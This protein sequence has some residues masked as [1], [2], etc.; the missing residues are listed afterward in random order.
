MDV[1]AHNRLSRLPMWAAVFVLSVCAAIVVLSGWSEW[2]SRDNTLRSAEIELGNLTR[3]LAQHAEDTI[4]LADATIRGAVSA[5][6]TDDGSVTTVLRLR[7]ILRSE[8]SSLGRIRG[9]FAYDENGRWLAT[10]EDVVLSN[11][12]NADRDYFGRHRK[13]ADRSL[14]IG[15]PVQSKSGRQWVI[16]LSRRWNHPD[17]RFAGVVVATIDVDY[18][19]GFY[20]RFDVGPHGTISLMSRDGTMLAHSVDLVADTAPQPLAD[21]IA[22]YPS[23]GILHVQFLQ[24]DSKRIGFYQ[25]G[26]R[27]PFLLLVT[28][29]Q[30]DVL[31]EWKRHSFVRIAV[32]VGLVLLILGIGL[33]LVRLILQGR[34]LASALLSRE[35]NFRLLAEDSSDIVARI[36]PDDRVRYISPSVVRVLGW[37]PAQLL[38]KRA[39]AG[40]HPLDASPI[41]EIILSI[42]R[43]ETEEARATYRIRRR[44]KSEIWVETALSASRNDDGTL[45]GFVAITRDVTQQMMLQGKLETLAVVDGLTGLA[46]R[47]RFDERLLEEWSRAYREKTSLGLLM[48]DIDHFKAFN[49]TYGH[50]A[51][52]ECLHTVAVVLAGEAQRPSDLAARYGGEEFAILLPNT[53]AAGC[54]RIGERIRRAIRET[55]I[56]HRGNAP[57]GIVTASIGGAVCRPGSE[58]PLEHASLIEAADRALY[59][60]KDGGRDRVIMAGELMPLAPSLAPDGDPSLDEATGVRARS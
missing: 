13:S 3:S 28:R 59:A 20:H 10:T 12:N 46:N 50:Q 22:F 4:E 33:F 37:T 52:D 34:R 9:V 5:L 17:G 24:D 58:R 44:D 8:K 39:L 32:I 47:R 29:T 14:L 40:I 60:A 43:G 16:S 38:G 48:I 49:D 54:A 36:G 45:D 23:S 27:Y 51:G 31:A 55:A 56:A 21:D 26:Q 6:E 2:A 30:E 18:F 15:G 7:A 35:K 19:S 11:D 25:R 57:F 41:E 1:V 53:D 42:K